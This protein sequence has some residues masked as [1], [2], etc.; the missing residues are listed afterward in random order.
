MAPLSRGKRNPPPGRATLPRQQR[1]PGATPLA[2]AI[3][4]RRARALPDLDEL[5]GL[6]PP[7]DLRV[8]HLDALAAPQQAEARARIAL[9][10]FQVAGVG[11]QGHGPA[12]LHDLARLERAVALDGARV[13]LEIRVG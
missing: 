3:G 7:V 2:T 10:V 12:R 6:P 13:H 4:A 11:P 5:P 8:E 1:N 9:P